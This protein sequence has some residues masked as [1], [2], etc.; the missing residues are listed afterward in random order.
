M[1]LDERGM[2]IAPCLNGR[3]S[4]K[5]GID[6]GALQRTLL[7]MTTREFRADAHQRQSRNYARLP[8]SNKK[9]GIFEVSDRS[10]NLK[11]TLNGG[12][13]KCTFSD[14]SMRIYGCGLHEG[15]ELPT[16]PGPGLP[17]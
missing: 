17:V 10:S 14:P 5:C 1:I 16:E 12:E 6:A 15:Q 8:G 7:A 11:I 9:K 2:P 13:S 4:W 3:G